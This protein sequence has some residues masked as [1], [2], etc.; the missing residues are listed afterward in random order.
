M[1][2]ALHPG[3]VKTGLSKEFW[4]NVTGEK[5]FTPEYAAERLVGEGGDP[6]L[7]RVSAAL[8]GEDGLG[9]L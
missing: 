6:A 2:V 1:A 9:W 3:T 8:A 7:V 4:G 5:L